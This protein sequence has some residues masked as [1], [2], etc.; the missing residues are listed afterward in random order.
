M[1]ALPPRGLIFRPI[2]DSSQIRIQ[3]DPRPPGY[4]VIW[5]NYTTLPDGMYASLLR[6]NDEFFFPRKDFRLNARPA[7]IINLAGD[8]DEYR[9]AVDW[10]DT[11]VR[12]QNF[13]VFNAPD[14]VKKTRRDTISSVLA[15]V[16]HLVVPK[17]VRFRPKHPRDFRETF[18]KEG[19]EYPVLVRLSGTQG[20]HSLIKISSADAWDDIFGIPWGGRVVYMTQFVDFSGGTVQFKKIRVAV[21]GD[22]HFVRHVKFGADWNV[23]NADSQNSPD[24]EMDIIGQLQADPAVS[25][26][27]ADVRRR[28]RLDFWGLD[29]GYVD[30]GQPLVLFE[31]NPAMH[32]V[33]SKRISDEAR[34]KDLSAATR[35]KLDL[36]DLIYDRLD[37]HLKTPRNWVART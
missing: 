31:G 25:A 8:Y 3:S 18:E 27:L 34:Q 23:H 17:C 14:E 30:E 10:L 33:L 20:G 19:F 7:H 12:A 22:Q 32:I 29:L 9:R 5:P 4:K 1:A 21:V 28:I 13:T 16:G 2:P 36:G 15:G 37:E 35:A 11:T 26:A 24:E 6:G